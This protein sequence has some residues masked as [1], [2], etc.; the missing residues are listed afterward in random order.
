MFF[1][2][3]LIVKNG[4]ILVGIYFIFLKKTP[5][6]K[7]EKISIPNSDLRYKIGKVVI[8]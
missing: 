4:P 8:K 6:T 2:A 3:V 5:N 1:L 7:L